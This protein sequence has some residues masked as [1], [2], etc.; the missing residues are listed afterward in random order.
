MI[1]K[2]FQQWINENK[3]VE[4][5]QPAAK[6]YASLSE[7]LERIP[8][9]AARLAPQST[10]MIAGTYF[11]MFG[12]NRVDLK[13]ID[14]ETGGIIKTAGADG[15]DPIETLLFKCLNELK[16]SVSANMKISSNQF[17]LAPGVT[18][19]GVKTSLEKSN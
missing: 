8:E 6:T 11:S 7:Y 14:V 17:P 3:L 18:I 15:T 5:S 10:H 1:I 9:I 13:L 16:A 4:E 12:S 2:S 19:T